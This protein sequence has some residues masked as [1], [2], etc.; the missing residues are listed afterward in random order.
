MLE[1]GGSTG[2]YYPEGGGG[3]GAGA[4]GALSL[5]VCFVGVGIERIICFFCDR[6]LG[7]EGFLWKETV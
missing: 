6:G 3:L 4:G 5:V 1:S 2:D 7:L